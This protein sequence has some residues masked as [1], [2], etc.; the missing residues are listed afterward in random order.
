MLIGVEW[1]EDVGIVDTESGHI[2]FY[3]YGRIKGASWYIPTVEIRDSD[4]RVLF[5][6]K[7][8][9]VEEYADY[10]VLATWDNV[11]KLLNHKEFRLTERLRPADED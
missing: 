9:T 5:G 1:D 4:F 3:C 8:E 2:L 6:K 11:C 10:S 7:P